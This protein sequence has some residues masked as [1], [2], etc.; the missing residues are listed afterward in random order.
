METI[1]KL[2]KKTKQE[3]S[4]Y[5][6]TGAVNTTTGVPMVNKKT[7]GMSNVRQL[8]YS[9]AGNE[10]KKDTKLV[11]SCNNK[12][13]INPEHLSYNHTV[14]NL[15]SEFMSQVD[16]NG[17][18]SPDITKAH[19]GPCWWWMGCLHHNR[20]YLNKDKW[21]EHIG[22]RWIYKQI[23]NL[24]DLPSHITVNHHCNN[25]RCVNPAHLYHI[26]GDT[27]NKANLSQAV[28]EKRVHNQKFTPD[29]VKTVRQRIL[30]GEKTSVLCKE[31]KC[32]KPTI[33]DIKFN[34]T[35]YDP[36]YIPPE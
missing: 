36:D 10:L 18:L 8:V 11:S 25:E 19:L 35:F 20:A 5:I 2:Y 15:L 13:C 1:D 7:W 27:F 31:F 33:A 17:Q 34:R 23:N 9:L 6:W 12:L 26:D 32:S 4:C 3:G 16:M 14:S 28:S 24:L 30:A 29:Q 22:A 21:G